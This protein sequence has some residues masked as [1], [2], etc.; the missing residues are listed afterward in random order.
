MNSHSNHTKW[1]LNGW[2]TI[3]TNISIVD[4][5]DIAESQQSTQIQRLWFN[6]SHATSIKS[7]NIKVMMRYD[8][9]TSSIQSNELRANKSVRGLCD[10]FMFLLRDM[11][12]FLL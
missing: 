8:F 3:Q 10:I 1:E 6:D 12:M 5:Q 11:F 9:H 7:I 4:D 2:M